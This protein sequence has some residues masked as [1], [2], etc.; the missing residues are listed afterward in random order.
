MS[1]SSCSRS[2]GAACTC[3]LPDSILA[4][5]ST[6]LIS[7]SSRLPALWMTRRR[8]CVSAGS[9]RSA[10][11]NCVNPST[12]F[13]GVRISWL[14][15][16]RNT[17][18][19]RLARSASSFATSSAAIMRRRSLTSRTTACSRFWSL[20]RNRLT[21]ISA[22]NRVPSRRRQRHSKVFM[23]PSLTSTT[24][25]AG[26]WVD[27]SP[28]AC[29]SGANRAVDW[30]SSP[31]RVPAPSSSTARRLQSTITAWRMIRIASPAVSNV[32]RKRAS[33]VLSARL[34]AW[35]SVMSRAM[36]T[37]PMTSPRSSRTAVFVTSSWRRSPPCADLSVSWNTSGSAA[38]SVAWS[39]AA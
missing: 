18:L 4:R 26:V 7:P 20:W 33:L 39:W 37:T 31:L 30:P 24:C 15:L 14:M 5:S 10:I 25:G 22:S 38:A 9:L 23:P 19:L 36:P 16:A 8:D 27:D 2:N 6:S 32:A 12:A 21:V 3:R 11:N 34:A 28:S 35:I 13:S 17:L 29:M 1:R